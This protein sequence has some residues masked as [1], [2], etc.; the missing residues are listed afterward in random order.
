MQF[1]SK[2]GFVQNILNFFPS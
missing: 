2:M 1:R